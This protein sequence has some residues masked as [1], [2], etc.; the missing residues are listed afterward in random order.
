MD[1]GQKY[2]GDNYQAAETET[3]T[4]DGKTTKTVTKEEHNVLLKKLNERLDIKGGA[5][6]DKLTENNIGVNVDS[7]TGV[8]KVQLAQNLDLTDK[9][10]VKMGNTTIK[11]AA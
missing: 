4:V 3:K 8:M 2:A 7:T 9:G 10:S 6:K 1:D 11:M 5:D